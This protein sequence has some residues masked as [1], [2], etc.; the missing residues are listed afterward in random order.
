MVVTIKPKTTGLK[1]RFASSKG[2]TLHIA[3][4]GIMAQGIN[5]PPPTQIAPNCPRAVKVATFPPVAV[6]N[7][8]AVEPARAIPE[9][10]EPS[11]PVIAPTVVTPKALKKLFSGT[12]L[13]RAY[14]KSF[15]IP[16][17]P[18]GK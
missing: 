13:E 10:P 15:T 7:K 17:E 5:V 16:K 14:P 2:D 1:L 11:S 9:N 8:F 3:E 12:A 4:T 18:L 6:P